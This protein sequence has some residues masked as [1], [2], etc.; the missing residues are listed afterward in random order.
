[1]DSVVF[2]F[3][4]PLPTIWLHLPHTLNLSV[5]PAQTTDQRLILVSN[6]PDAY[7]GQWDYPVSTGTLQRSQH[8]SLAKRT[9]QASS[10]LYSAPL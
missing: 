2:P 7:P 8:C 6:V 3:Q 5:L 4:Q 10:P 9:V 1:M